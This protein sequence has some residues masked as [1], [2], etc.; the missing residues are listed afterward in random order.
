MHPF[1]QPADLAV[2]VLHRTEVRLKPLEVAWPCLFDTHNEVRFA[3]ARCPVN[4]SGYYI[5]EPIPKCLKVSWGR[6]HPPE[7]VR[8]GVI[9]G[10]RLM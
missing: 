6:C 8:R 1:F 7:F 5:R 4:L 9:A 2:S 10:S 3:V